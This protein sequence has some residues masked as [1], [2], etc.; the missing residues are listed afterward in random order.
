MS[1]NKLLRLFTVWPN[2][3]TPSA[4]QKTRMIQYLA[5][6]TKEGTIQNIQNQNVQNMMRN[7][8]VLQPKKKMNHPEKPSISPSNLLSI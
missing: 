3:F 8:P 7:H 4:K 1:P 2:H 6:E 5:P